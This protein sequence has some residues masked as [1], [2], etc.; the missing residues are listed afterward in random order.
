MSKII[1]D[2]SKI[3]NVPARMTE[4]QIKA[5]SPELHAALLKLNAEPTGRLLPS[6]DDR[7]EYKQELLFLV[8]ENE[9]NWDC[10]TAT[11]AA[12]FYQPKSEVETREDLSDLDWTPDHFVIID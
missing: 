5:I 8:N 4:N 2:A 6:H 10:H 12:I 3:A 11:A 1:I 7:V 9:S